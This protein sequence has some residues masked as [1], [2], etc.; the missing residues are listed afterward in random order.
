MDLGALRVP[1][2]EAYLG[3]RAALHNVPVVL[4]SYEVRPCQVKLVL[5]D[6]TGYG[7]E[8][9]GAQGRVGMR[10]VCVVLQSRGAR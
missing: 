3:H 1:L 4:R 8:V 6:T 9:R 7:P 10:V 5:G 2:V